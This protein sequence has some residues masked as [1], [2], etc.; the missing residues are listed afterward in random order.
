MI[1]L[2]VFSC[3]V[4]IPIKV[5]LGCMEEEESE[6]GIENAHRSGLAVLVVHK[7]LGP[8]FLLASTNRVPPSMTSVESAPGC[9]SVAKSVL[10]SVG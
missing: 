9:C 8:D 10:A 6:L 5:I 1:Q 3:S 7:N 2:R 4:D